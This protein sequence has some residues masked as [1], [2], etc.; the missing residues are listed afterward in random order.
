MTPLTPPSSPQFPLVRSNVA[1]AVF[2]KVIR[3][4]GHVVGHISKWYAAAAAEM[5]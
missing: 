1:F 4:F 5:R 3:N 2:A